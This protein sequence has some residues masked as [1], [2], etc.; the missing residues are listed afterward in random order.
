MTPRVA[1]L[2]KMTLRRDNK[3]HDN[4]IKMTLRTIKLCI[5][6]LSIETHQNDT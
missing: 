5:G 2:N 1:S 6:I 4:A 3:R